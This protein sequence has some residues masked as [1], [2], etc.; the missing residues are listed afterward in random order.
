MDDQLS[1]DEENVPP[2]F[3]SQ[4]PTTKQQIINR[5]NPIDIRGKWS[6]QA[7]EE[8]M[9]AVERRTTSLRKPSKH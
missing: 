6:N 9:D 1:Q 4:E 7:L 5:Y 8:A 2:S 3:I